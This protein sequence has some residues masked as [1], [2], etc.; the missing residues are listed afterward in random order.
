MAFRSGGEEPLG[1]ELVPVSVFFMAGGRKSSQAEAESKAGRG[2]GGGG[3]G[4]GGGGGGG[5]GDHTL[6]TRSRYQQ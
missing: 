2:S 6:I 3:D 1:P 5:G 4:G